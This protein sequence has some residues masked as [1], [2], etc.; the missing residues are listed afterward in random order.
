MRFGGVKCPS[1]A[2]LEIIRESALIWRGI[3]AA[4][5]G[6]ERIRKEEVDVWKRRVYKRPWKKQPARRLEGRILSYG[7]GGKDKKFSEIV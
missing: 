3:L 2:M 5:T 7:G 4:V 6:K 1:A